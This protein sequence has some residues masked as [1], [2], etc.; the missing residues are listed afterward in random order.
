MLKSAIEFR[1]TEAPLHGLQQPDFGKAVPGVW[2]VSV[3]GGISSGPLAHFLFLLNTLRMGMRQV[4]SRLH[5]LIEPVVNALGYELV[6]I[7]QTSGGRAAVLRI[8]IDQ[9]DGITVDD[10]ERVSH[11]V[12]GLLDVEDP[13]RGG[14]VLEVSSPGLDRPLFRKA[15]FDRFSGSEVKVRLAKP[16]AGRRNFTGVL[17]GLNGNLVVLEVDE[18]VF[19]LPLD[20]IQKARLVY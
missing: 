13:I 7:E 3:R 20:A 11:Q 8:Y 19:E 9:E 4:D 15:D 2:F 12:S 5:G 1:E 16:V 18:D 17:R 6:G 10:C 14:Y